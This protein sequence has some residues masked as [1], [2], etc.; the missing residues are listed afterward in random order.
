MSVDLSLGDEAEAIAEMIR[1]F[2][3]DH[4]GGFVRDRWNALC[5]LGLF[6]IGG[7]KEIVAAMEALG[8]A[9]IAGPLEGTFVTVR[10]LG[11]EHSDALTSGA[12]LVSLGI[13]PLMPWAQIAA[14]F[15]LRDGARAFRGRAL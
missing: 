7:A 4:E 12:A 5:E 3:R 9:N 2:A 10:L 1:R 14:Q 15:V 8:K 6:T 11:L 13:P